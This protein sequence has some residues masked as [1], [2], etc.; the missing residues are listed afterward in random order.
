LGDSPASCS[1]KSNRALLEEVVRLQSE[2][3][4]VPQGEDALRDERRARQML[5]GAVKE[6]RRSGRIS[7]PQRLADSGGPPGEERSRPGQ[8]WPRPGPARRLSRLAWPPWS[9]SWRRSSRQD[10]RRA[11]DG[12]RLLEEMR[13]PA[14]SSARDCRL[15]VARFEPKPKNGGDW[16]SDWHERL[17]EALKTAG[18]EQHPR[19]GATD[20]LALAGGRL[21]QRARAAHQ[22]GQQRWE[23]VAQSSGGR[24]WPEPAGPSGAELARGG[25]RRLARS[26]RLCSEMDASSQ[27]ETPKAAKSSED[28]SRLRQQLTARVQELEAR[29]SSSSSALSAE[30]KNQWESLLED[31]R[32]ET[33]R[34]IA[35]TEEQ[36]QAVKSR[37]DRMDE[38]LGGRMGEVHRNSDQI[39]ALMED[40]SLRVGSEIAGRV[41]DTDSI[42]VE[43]ERLKASSSVGGGD[44]SGL[45]RELEECQALVRKLAEVVQ[46]VKTV[47]GMKIQSEQKLRMAEL[48]GMQEEM[49]QHS[50]KLD[51]LASKVNGK[52]SVA[53]RMPASPCEYFDGSGRVQLDLQFTESY[54]GRD[55]DHL[56][57]LGEVRPIS[58]IYGKVRHLNSSA[59]AATKETVW[60][61][62][63][64]DK[65]ENRWHNGSQF[66]PLEV[67]FKWT[68]ERGVMMLRLKQGIDREILNIYTAGSPGVTSFRCCN[69]VSHRVHTGTPRDSPSV[70]LSVRDA[71]AAERAVVAFMHR[72]SL[73]RLA[74]NSPEIR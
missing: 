17:T 50:G 22:A 29:L 25:P 3:Q 20:R 7:W 15:E 26:R 37:L 36:L 19:A 40:L 6:Q 65:R 63:W 39:T 18:T 16:S 68:I 46:T 70:G 45:K 72:H 71:D 48:K 51:Q 30:S 41:Q 62:P 74:D 52:K 67:Y 56:P 69:L 13:K 5:E 49:K 54:G 32:R 42:R 59:S 10:A 34:R 4:V 33:G 23:G 1:E 53:S 38:R 61:R 64:D 47:L 43:L 55:G 58:E 44:S 12:A 11:P 57:T 28:E 14:G 31:Y 8:L 9:A 21:T 66:S 60:L 35:G 24:S 2:A 27:I 73:F